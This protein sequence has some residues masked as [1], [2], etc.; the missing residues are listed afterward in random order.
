MPQRPSQNW[1]GRNFTSFGPKVRLDMANPQ[2]GLNGC[3]VY[4]LYAVSDNNDISLIGMSEGGILH[5]Y[6]DQCIE[7]I[8]GQK[9]RSTG[10]DIVITGK[11]G[12]VTITAEKNGQIKIRGA[13]VT[14]NADENI[15]LIAGK[16]ITLKSGNAINLKSNI[17]N[18]DALEGNLAP[19]DQTWGARVFTGTFIGRDIIARQFAGTRGSLLGAVTNVALGAATNV[20]LGAATNVALGAAASLASGVGSRGASSGS[21]GGS[22]GGSS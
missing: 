9:S 8:G 13:S 16:N 4:D 21:S 11:N 7:I 15:E 5:I 10:I 2:M 14:I 18:C 19:G 3:E 20:A 22:S 6:N 17:A 1:E 12:D